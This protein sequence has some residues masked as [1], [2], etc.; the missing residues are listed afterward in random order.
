MHRTL[1]TTLITLAI[2]ATLSNAAEIEV[3]MLNSGEEGGMVFEPAFVQ[4]EPGDTIRFLPTD[5]GHNV[6]SINDMLP[7]GVE[8]F[9]SD[10]NQ[11]FVLEIKQDGVYGIKCTPHYGMGMIGLIAA[12]DLSNLDEAR[13]VKHRGKAGKRFAKVFEELDAAFASTPGVTN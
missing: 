3:K 4:A 11:E 1:M 5:K 8:T 9:K 6:E 13:A 2:G 12:G 10:L 7:A